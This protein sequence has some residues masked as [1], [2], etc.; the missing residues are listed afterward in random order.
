MSNI[1]PF[2]QSASIQV[3]N[4]QPV[5]TSLAVAKHFNKRHDTVLRA[6]KNLDCSP[7][8]TGRN[9]EVSEYTDST[10]RDLPMY[11]I[12]RD[13][14]VFLC[15]GFTGKEAAKWKEAYINAFNA[16]EKE[17]RRLQTEQ[18]KLHVLE[19]EERITRLEKAF[20]R[21]IQPLEYAK[22]NTVA[23]TGLDVRQKVLEAIR[24]A[25]WD[26]LTKKDL[27]DHCRPFRRLDEP[28]RKALLSELLQAGEL[29]EVKFGSPAKRPSLKLL[30][31]SFAEEVRS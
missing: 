23:E 6:V 13:G 29:I 1:V 4:G 30:H 28:D 7:E 26:G 15:M 8:F 24:K 19:L 21:P 2:T 3:I 16:M 9:F 14:F 31:P 18:G 17:I 27:R 10:G 20:K 12:T 25:G 11:R 5:T 22:K